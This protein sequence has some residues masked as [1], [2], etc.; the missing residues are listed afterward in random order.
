MNFFN[1]Y[2]KYFDQH[3]IKIIYLHNTNLVREVTLIELPVFFWIYTSLQIRY[4]N[5]YDIHEHANRDIVRCLF[6]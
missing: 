6:N 4:D 3:H 1:N 2:R 5:N